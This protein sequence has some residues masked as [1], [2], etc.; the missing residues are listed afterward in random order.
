MMD[1]L[2]L[3]G[4]AATLAATPAVAKVTFK[5]STFAGDFI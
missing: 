4:A 1:R 3:L 2:T 5:A